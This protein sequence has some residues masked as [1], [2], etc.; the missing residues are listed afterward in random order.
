MHSLGFGTER[1]VWPVLKWPR[2]ALVLS[3]LALVA[4]A[5]GIVHVGFNENLRDVFAG[6]NKAYDNYVEVT[7]Q[8]VDPEN[9]IYLLI[10]GPTIGAPDSFA[11]LR[12]LQFEL[13]LVD[14]VGSVYS[15]FALRDAPDENGDAALTTG[16]NETRLTPELIAKIRS[17]PLLGGKLLSAGADAAVFVVTPEQAKAPVAVTNALIETITATAKEV[18]GNA[19]LTTSVT[20]FPA[21]RGDV[22]DIMIHDQ[23]V[24]NITGAAIGLL[25]SLIVFRSFIAALMTALPAMI[26]GGMVLGVMGL[27]G[28]E[29]TVMSNIIP[30][31]V[32]ILGYADATHLSFAWRHNRDLG[33][34]P[35]EAEQRAQREVGP[36]CMLTAITTALAFLSLTIS[37]VGVVSGF[38]WIGAIGTFLGGMVVLIFHAVLAQT[39]GRYWKA[40]SRATPNI[41]GHLRHPSAVICRFSLKHARRI[42]ILAVV[43]FIAF[44]TMH[45]SVPPQ[46]SMREHLSDSKPSNAAL[47]R[48]DRLFDGAYPMQIVIPLDSLAATSPEGLEKIG[49]VHA[50][51]AAIDGANTPLSLWSVRQ[52]LGGDIASA[53]Q[54]LEKMLADAPPETASRFINLAGTATLMSVNLRE[55]PTHVIEPLI[56][57]VETA[58]RAAGGSSVTVTGLAVLSARESGRSISILN[59]S[60]TLAILS[61]LVAMMLAFRNWRIGIVAFLPNAL[62]IVTTG[63]LLFMTG[64]GMQYTSVLSLTVAFGIAIDDTIH[65]L[66]RFGIEKAP[67]TLDGRLIE[68]SRHIGPVLLGTTAIIIAGLSTTLFSSL[69]SATLFGEL[70][71]V[72]LA[73]ALVGDLLVLPALMAGAGRRWFEPKTSSKT[74]AGEAPARA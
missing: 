10:E 11:R 17:H 69:P 45:F 52:W 62:P 68:T 38:G 3:L 51:V 16:E 18:L 28:V 56:T 58:A 72:T 4:A 35:A 71:A 19:D 61:G 37:D 13:Q 57:R 40:S 44:A 36:A 67:P 25:M 34:T 70:A 22:V 24:L 7:D 39:L 33:A 49:K 64:R 31:L 26:A 20:G 14:G 12:N 55:A 66:N 42:E 60:L 9:E 74:A 48:I 32:M 47:G 65:Y 23:L 53:S 6:K 5:Y 41:L 8:F 73:A 54:R 1:V 27:T 59:L 30:A 2:T 63:A 21:I 43:L 15:M 50:A 29:M 46:H